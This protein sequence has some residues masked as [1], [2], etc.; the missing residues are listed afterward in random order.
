MLVWFLHH[1]TCPEY[2][3]WSLTSWGI[4]WANFLKLYKLRIKWIILKWRFSSTP[5]LSPHSYPPTSYYHFC[6][7]G[8]LCL[9]M[10][11]TLWNYV[12]LCISSQRHAWCHH[13]GVG[14][15]LAIVALSVALLFSCPV[16]S[17]S[18][19]THGLQHDRPP[20]PSPPP[21]LCPSSCSLHWWCCPAISS[22]DALFFCPQ[23]FSAS[24][25]FPMNCLLA[26]NDQ[27]TG[28]SPSGKYSWLI[29]LK[30]DWFDLL[31]AQGTFRSLLQHHSSKASIL[32]R[33]TLGSSSHN[34]I[35]PLGRS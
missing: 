3:C 20:C 11:K 10:M 1:A 34:R 18:L 27:S 4:L 35:W 19:W 29:S 21:R 25:T 13:V 7:W 8:Y 2:A 14:W 17:N 24:G 31:A 16:V 5:D 28:A 6:F 23:S 12:L 22:A 32:W 15:K 9:C 30:I 26:S 33:S